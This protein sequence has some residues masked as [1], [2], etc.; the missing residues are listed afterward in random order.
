MPE[1]TLPNAAILTDKTGID[2][3]RVRALK[4][5][6]FLKQ[7]LTNNLPANRNYVDNLVLPDDNDLVTV[8]TD[9]GSKPTTGILNEGTASVIHG[10]TVAA[11]SP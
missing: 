4:G 7:Y 5:D 6:E 9:I 8:S 2:D 10:E 1:F 11:P 3:I